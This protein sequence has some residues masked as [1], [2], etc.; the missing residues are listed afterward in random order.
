MRH[1]NFRDLIIGMVT[2]GPPSSNDDPSPHWL[3][4]EVAGARLLQTAERCGLRNG[5]QVVLRTGLGVLGDAC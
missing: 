3:E 4:W 1:E 2:K 5:L